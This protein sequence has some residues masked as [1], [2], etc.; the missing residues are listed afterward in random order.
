M[1]T[2][3]QTFTENSFSW[4]FLTFQGLCRHPSCLFSSFDQNFQLFKKDFSLCQGLGIFV[5]LTTLKIQINMIN[6]SGRT[7]KP[8]N[9]MIG[10]FSQPFRTFELHFD[11]ISFRKKANIFLPLHALTGCN[12]SWLR[13][14][15]GFWNRWNYII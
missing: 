2:G 4:W 15:M 1:C 8:D 12:R 10:R 13:R 5:F 14:L 9:W 7:F 6:I 3:I 11:K